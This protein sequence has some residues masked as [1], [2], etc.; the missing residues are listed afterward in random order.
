MGS[1]LY[2]AAAL[3]S[4][5]PARAAESRFEWDAPAACPS[6]AEVRAAIGEL[7][8]PA[9]LDFGS[10]RS[11]RAYVEKRGEGWELMLDF[12]DGER[13]R[14]R[15]ITALE[16]ADLLEAARIAIAL[17]VESG[18]APGG[19][20]ASSVHGL[21]GA[22]SGEAPV[23][24]PALIDAKGDT[25]QLPLADAKT[26][27]PPTPTRVGLQ[28]A[29]VVDGAALPGAALG[30][31]VGA[32]L[33]RGPWAFGPYVLFLPGRERAAGAVARVGFS[34]L[35]GGLRACHR[36][37]GVS[38]QTQACAAVEAGRLYSSGE[39]LVDANRYSDWWVTPSAGLR[40][41]FSLG[42]GWAVQAQ[43]DALVP[44][45]RESY[46]VNQTERVHRPPSVGLR[47]ALGISLF[48]D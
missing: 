39:G 5:R 32:E 42:D 19:G 25:S 43:G 13:K 20:V 4:V 36:L 9:P 23:P 27:E 22:A 15:V 26:S 31:S 30:V 41:A 17:A 46:V 35:A 45:L 16:C 12:L 28:T 33:L 47:A 8:G 14:S 2:L 11:I 3:A 7:L 1:A 40:F 48:L 38:V 10:F 37:S 24:S 6:G 44:F 21:E 34:L 18:A 29:G